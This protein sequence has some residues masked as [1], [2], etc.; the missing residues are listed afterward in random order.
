MSGCEWVGC[1]WS[2]TLPY[3]ATR[4]LKPAPREPQMPSEPA[5]PNN[6]SPSLARSSSVGRSAGS[7]AVRFLQQQQQ[8][9]A[10]AGVS[11]TSVMDSTFHLTS[12]S[13][14]GEQPSG[15]TTGAHCYDYTYVLPSD[16]PRGRSRWSLRG[17]GG[18]LGVEQA[19]MTLSED[20]KKAWVNQNPPK[21]AT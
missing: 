3:N 10:L 8:P 20:K 2:G 12:V 16:A 13:R 5:S 1:E 18:R 21:A 15:S 6:R 17:E 7:P 4:A 9:E 11:E 19:R 14:V